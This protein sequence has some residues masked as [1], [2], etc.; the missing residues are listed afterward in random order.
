[1]SLL[2]D[3]QWGPEALLD[4]DGDPIVPTLITVPDGYTG[5]AD[6]EGNLTIVG[7]PADAVEVE[8]TVGGVVS[9]FTLTIPAAVDELA[10]VADLAR[11]AAPAAAVDELAE[12]SAASDSRLAADPDLLIFGTLTRNADG[13]VTSADVLWPDG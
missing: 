10:E 2:T 7:P 3:G 6:A 12:Q 9:T 13:A 5:E 11:A 1:M 4:S 8:I